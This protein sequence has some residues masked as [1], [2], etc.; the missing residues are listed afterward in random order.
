M[1]AKAAGFDPNVIREIEKMH[2]NLGAQVYRRILKGYRVWEP[3][4]IPDPETAA[5]VL[6]EMQ[7]VEKQL[8]RAAH[9]FDRIGRTAGEEILCSFTLKSISDFGDLSTL[10]RVVSALEEKVSTLDSTS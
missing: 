10:E 6:S 4:Q 9:A 2:S 8:H 7:S 5:K 3:A 1:R